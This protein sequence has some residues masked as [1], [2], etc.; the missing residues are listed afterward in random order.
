MRDYP[1]SGY[2]PLS[3][4]I[5]ASSAFSQNQPDEAK[6]YLQWVIDNARRSELQDLAKLRMAKLL[7]ESGDHDAALAMLKQADTGTLRASFDEQR[8]DILTAKGI[9][10]EAAEAYEAALQA[11]GVTPTTQRRLEMKLDDLGLGG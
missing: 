8:G 10:E 9:H 5:R 3:G 2:A 1:N 11:E 7:T 4:L 6:A